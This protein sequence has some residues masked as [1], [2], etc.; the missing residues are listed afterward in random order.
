MTYYVTLL[1]VIGASASPLI[2]PLL[3]LVIPCSP[4]Y[5]GNVLVD[6]GNPEMISYRGRLFVYFVEIILITAA[7]MTTGMLSNSIVGLAGLLSS[8]I[9]LDRYIP[10]LNA[11]N[12]IIDLSYQRYAVLFF[13]FSSGVKVY[14][15][16][17]FIMPAEEES[18]YQQRT[19][20]RQLQ[21]LVKLYNASFQMHHLPNVQ[22]SCSAVIIGSLFG[23][24]V[25][26]GKVAL[27]GYL[28]FPFFCVNCAGILFGTIHMCSC[29]TLSSI[30]LKRKWRQKDNYGGSTW[31]R[32]FAKSCPDL[33]IRI[34]PFHVVDRAKL[35][36]VYRF[37]LQRTFFCV[38]YSRE[39]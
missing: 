18:L 9:S 6:C 36:L 31:F 23:A 20:Y 14:K 39:S 13:I 21:L 3:S 12:Q 29:I 30:S 37:C 17:K 1:L 22:C 26:H 2:L 33:K 7:A 16:P 38:V 5:L 24:I 10:M 27:P 8:Y 4:Q 25:L 28:A 34:G 11:V 19:F 15:T 35:A 32:A